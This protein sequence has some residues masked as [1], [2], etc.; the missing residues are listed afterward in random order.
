MEACGRGL[1]VASVD[2]GIMEATSRFACSLL[3]RA[4]CLN[5][6]L[7]PFGRYLRLIFL[8]TV[9]RTSFQEFDWEG[10]GKGYCYAQTK[11]LFWLFPTRRERCVPSRVLE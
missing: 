5:P 2:S 8:A 11:G 10:R 6:I 3:K 9:T 1:R 7:F 4:A